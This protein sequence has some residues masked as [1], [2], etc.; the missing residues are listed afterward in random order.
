MSD[1]LPAGPYKSIPF[2]GGSTLP[3]YIIPFDKKGRCEGPETQRHLL[4]NAA[5]HSD[6]F[7][8]SH[9]WNNDWQTATNH[10]ENF[11]SGFMKMRRDNNL[12][13]PPNYRPLLV[14]VFWPSTALVKDDEQAPQMAA[15]AVDDDEV[16]DERATIRGVAEVLPDAKVERFYELTQRERLDETE[17]RELAGILQ[18]LFGSQSDDLS[19][20]SAPSV[21]E[22]LQ[23]WQRTAPAEEE[24]VNFEDFG[25]VDGESGAGVQGA[26]GV[27]DFFKSILPRKIVRGFTV[28]QMKDR[29]GTVGT[30]GVGPMLAELLKR[31]TARVHLI[32]HSYG[33]KVVL[34]ALCSPEAMGQRKV[35]ST[36]LLQ[37]AV[38]HLCF[39]NKVPGTERAGGYARALDRI[40]RPI[41]STFSDHDFPLTQI[42]HLALVREVDLGELKIAADGKPPSRYAAL[43]G[44]GPR[45]A[46]EKLIEILDR[47]Q[48][49]QLDNGVRVY[50]L[51]G[52]RTIDGHGGISNESTWWALYNLVRPA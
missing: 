38:S 52:T 25:T 44:F 22:L 28:W 34:S 43:G 51:N 46:N 41:L 19:N 39:A 47:P 33:A 20:M 40:E 9:G 30:R 1:R 17:A 48:P 13:V 6:I 26:G 14:G 12:P 4:D 23:I 32:G 5:S 49:Y 3:Y 21:D 42:F 7:L 27:G 37:P 2:D 8:F 36:L 10:Y 31:T 11:I 45:G 16:A 50:G 35:H 15:D 29:A 24:K 18:P